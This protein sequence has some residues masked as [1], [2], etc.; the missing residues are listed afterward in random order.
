[1]DF[2]VFLMQSHLILNTRIQKLARLLRDACPEIHIVLCRLTGGT[3]NPVQQENTSTSDISN[4]SCDES[5]DESFGESTNG[6]F[7]ARPSESTPPGAI[8]NFVLALTL[9]SYQTES[10]WDLTE[11]FLI[12]LWARALDILSSGVS[13]YL[14]VTTLLRRFQALNYRK[15]GNFRA[16]DL[17]SLPARELIRKFREICC[18]ASFSKYDGYF[19]A[20]SCGEL[21]AREF[22]EKGYFFASLPFQWHLLHHTKRQ[23]FSVLDWKVDYTELDKVRASSLLHL[24]RFFFSCCSSCSSSLDLQRLLH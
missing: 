21:F 9:D 12:M 23:W 15:R 2:H 11:L 4:S 19:C 8:T 13:G 5:F 16:I 3:N 1:M 17:I 22:I 18:D 6:L 24:T 20:H 7:F 10:D 14:P